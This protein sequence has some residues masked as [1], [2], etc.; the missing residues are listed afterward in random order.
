[1]DKD[2][3][4]NKISSSDYETIE[5]RKNDHEYEHVVR[6]DLE[7]SR[8]KESVKHPRKGFISK[9]KAYIVGFVVILIASVAV[10]GGISYAMAVSGRYL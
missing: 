10:S 9:H 8:S 7:H 4:E 3:N 5:A 2:Q 1:M 6:P